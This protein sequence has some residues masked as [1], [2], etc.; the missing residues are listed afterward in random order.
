LK[1]TLRPGDIHGYPDP[2]YF[3]NVLNEL[4]NFGIEPD[5]GELDE[6]EDEPD[7]SRSASFGTIVQYQ[8]SFYGDPFVDTLSGPYY[9]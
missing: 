1:T 7:A 3:R 9:K 5:E 4:K 2:A 8:P 6:I